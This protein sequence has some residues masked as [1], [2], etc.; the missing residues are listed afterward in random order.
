MQ[1]TVHRKGA[2]MER[3]FGVDSLLSR[4]LTV[5]ANTIVLSLL[6]II[7]CVPLITIGASTT[8]AYYAAI[9][10]LNGDKSIFR[11]Y[12]KSF[13]LNLKQAIIL[14]VILGIPMIVLFGGIY[15]VVSMGS[16]I[17]TGIAVAYG[18]LAFGLLAVCS[19]AFPILSYFHFPTGILL[20]NAALIALVNTGWTF[21]IIFV[22][23]LP[24]LIPALRMDWALMI[25]PLLIALVPGSVI[26]INSIIFKRIF[27]QYV[28]EEDKLQ[29]E[30]PG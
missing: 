8:A 6:W 26:E 5:L 24:L 12:I 17:P 4:I 15:I 25:L 23:L 28:R 3:I 19:Y 10:A 13:K 18:V 29:T 14:E 9:H 22:N 11:N 16:M 30:Q 1:Y 27:P 20:K 7:G 2:C 21:V